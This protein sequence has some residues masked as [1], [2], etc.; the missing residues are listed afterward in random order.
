MSAL[1]GGALLA[2]GIRRGWRRGAP[3]ALVGSALLQRGVTGH[4]YAYQALG[5][6][7]RQ[8][9]PAEHA[10]GPRTLS[11]SIT[12][13]RPAAELRA[14]VRDSG[15]LARVFAELAEVEETPHGLRFDVRLP[16]GA[17]EFL[18]ERAE[19]ALTW[20][21]RAVDDPGSVLAFRSSPGSE[22]AHE[23]SFRF[24]PAPGG[25]G[26]EVTLELLLDAGALADTAIHALSFVPANA[27]Q[28][29]LRR[30][31]SLVETGE[32]PTTERNPSA[33]M[34]AA[35]RGARLA[36]SSVVS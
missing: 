21:A 8:R 28:R 14:F 15:N 1:L 36:T 16:Q 27:L 17:Y 18:P 4:C 20:E 2:F 30:L 33:R 10:S 3:A 29:A 9:G 19:R 25:R 32:T 7:T 5:V 31:K 22:H 34:P 35:R 13:G 24:R 23:L 6:N 26:T 11:R 12:V